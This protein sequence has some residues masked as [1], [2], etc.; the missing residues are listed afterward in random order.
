[1]ENQKYYVG[2]AEDVGL[3]LW[4]HFKMNSKTGS[5][6]TKKYKPLRVLHI[7]EI[8]QSKWKYKAVERECVLRIAK[9]VGFAN[10]RGAGFSLSQEA[11]PANWDDKLVEI[12]AADFSK[13]TPPTKEEL[14]NLMKGK[15]QLWLARKK[16]IQGRQ[17]AMS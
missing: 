17:K 7:S 2:I 9:A 6:W 4:T 3:R 1:M 11:Y 5:A 10:V 16:N 8:K 15:Y 13:M 14:K 12:P